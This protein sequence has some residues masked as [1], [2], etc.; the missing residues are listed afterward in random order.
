MRN[1]SSLYASRQKQDGRLPLWILS[2]A[3]LLSLILCF[4]VMFYAMQVPPKHVLEQVQ[5]QFASKEG[6]TPKTALSDV[7][8][9]PADTR[10]LS[11]YQ[12]I[13]QS[14]LDQIPAD[15]ATLTMDGA[16]I[17]IRL[18]GDAYFTPGSADIPPAPKQELANLVAAISRTNL[19][20]SVI[21]HT[22]PAPLSNARFSSNW[23]LSLARAQ[24][25]AS[26]IEANGTPIYKIWGAASG[27]YGQISQDLALEARYSKAR[28][29]DIVLTLP[30]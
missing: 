28:R 4:F 1:F 15:H 25:I 6:G 27:N 23:A 30:Q 19:R 26:L 2:L 9:T 20:V 11:Y 16:R 7:I 21:G 22:D 10:G 29:V 8:A 24:S 18:A 17:T 12:H 13:L 3:D 5:E 14:Q